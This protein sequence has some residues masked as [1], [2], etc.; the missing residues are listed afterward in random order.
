MQ[1]T[2]YKIKRNTLSTNRYYTKRISQNVSRYSLS[3]CKI[4]VDLIDHSK[5]VCRI[6]FV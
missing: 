1:K 6:I 5:S 2:I 3:N 4:I